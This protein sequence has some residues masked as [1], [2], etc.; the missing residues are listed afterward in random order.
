MSRTHETGIFVKR[1][2]CLTVV[3]KILM[4]M[5]VKPPKTGGLYSPL[6]ENKTCALSALIKRVR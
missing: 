4:A 5:L 6:N 2:H 1:P 3:G